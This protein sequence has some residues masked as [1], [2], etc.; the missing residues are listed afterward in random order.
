VKTTCL[1]ANYII[2]IQNVWSYLAEQSPGL[3]DAKMSKKGEVDSKEKKM[4]NTIIAAIR[5]H[6]TVGLSDSL[7]I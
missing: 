3:P 7:E 6:K 4:L 5:K 2:P 1:Y